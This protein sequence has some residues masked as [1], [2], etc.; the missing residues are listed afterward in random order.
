MAL[1]ACS[2]RTSYGRVSRFVKLVAQ[3]VLPPSSFGS[4]CQ[5]NSAKARM[6][7]YMDHF[8]RLRR[9]DSATL[10]MLVDTPGLR[11]AV[12]RWVVNDL[13]VPLLRSM[14]Y[15][16]EDG[17]GDTWYFRKPTW[18]ALCNRE[19]RTLCGLDEN[20]FGDP[21]APGSGTSMLAST[22]GAMLQRIRGPIGKAASTHCLVAKL[23]FVPKPNGSLRP[24][25]NCRAHNFRLVY[26]HVALMAA[27]RAAP[28]FS[29][30]AALLGLDDLYTAYRAFVLKARSCGTGPYLA[31]AMD[32][33]KC[34]DMMDQG[35]ACS[36]L[37]D[38][39]AGR[40]FHIRGHQE[41]FVNRACQRVRMVAKRHASCS[42]FKRCAGGKES[43]AASREATSRQRKVA[44]VADENCGQGQVERPKSDGPSDSMLDGGSA[45]VAGAAVVGKRALGRDGVKR[46]KRPAPGTAQATTPM[47]QASQAS[48][49]ENMPLTVFE[50]ARQSK[51][52][53]LLVDRAEHG[54]VTAR[55]VGRKVAGAASNVVV[56]LG[57]RQF[58][59]LRGV[60]QG[61]TLS[62]LL[63]T[64]HLARFEQKVVDPL[65]RNQA[66]A[67]KDANGRPIL[68]V[69]L[70]DDYLVMCTERG[71]LERLRAAMEVG[72][73][74]FGV[75][76]SSSK[77][78][79]SWEHSARVAWCGLLVDPCDFSVR[80]DPARLEARPRPLAPD[81]RRQLRE[82][83]QLLAVRV[84]PI[85]FDAAFNS[86]RVALSNLK[87]LL[88]LALARI[89]PARRPH[90]A[91][92]LARFAHNLARARCA[93]HSGRV[94]TQ[95]RSALELAHQLA[96]DEAPCP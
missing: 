33:H 70:L 53:R 68:A 2:A 38:L 1:N 77:T 92:R 4:A 67:V 95:L 9:S 13:L 89:E 24:I 35:R 87:C 16:T 43:T 55:E 85:L 8:V 90:C 32:V 30:C 93:Q 82:A 84:W 69:R 63:C 83:M 31:L 58:K 59:M 65:L 18:A 26:T 11:E 66:G 91:A 36:A 27:H 50:L 37:Q 17:R 94:A 73:A 28:S 45:S 15:C 29:A 86:A 41:F 14:F 34:F 78:R 81:G 54:L 10:D 20:G 60:P 5:Q 40:E 48:G 88:Q 12:V 62:P 42:T 76:A 22:P 56:Q 3:R 51:R 21:I 72:E 7:Q 46:A 80:L 19:L 47:A 75:R 79:A 25:M 96:R 39:V 61:S 57:Q 23:R 49:S 52:R 71:R 74:D 64:A 6:W 44:P